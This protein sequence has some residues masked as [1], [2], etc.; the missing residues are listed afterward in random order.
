M[1][2]ERR[3][4]AGLGR[5][6]KNYDRNAQRYDR[7][8]GLAD[9]LTRDA[10]QKVG[11]TVTGHLLEVGIGSGLSL[12]YYPPSVQVTGVD[13]S[14][15]MLGICR[16]R[17]AE[18]GVAVQLVEQDAQAL[19]FRDASFD[20]VAFNLCLCTIPDPLRALQEGL[21]VARPGAHMV[22]FEHVRS[23]LLPVALLQELINPLT[24]RFDSDHFNR[25]TLDNVRAAGVE[26]ISVKR[27][28][29]GFFNL[30]VGRAPLA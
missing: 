29:L 8:I 25:R 26:V 2:P 30:I 17:A 4:C 1:T 9:W 13:L 14:R 12:P 24:V 5:I 3:R 16:Q 21:R 20:S 18:L 22:F 10:R 15:V 7:G 28:A 23:H 6:R 19:P 27:W 11:E